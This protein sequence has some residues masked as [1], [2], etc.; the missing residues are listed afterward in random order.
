MAKTIAE[1]ESKVNRLAKAFASAN[2]MDLQTLM[3]YLD[4][5]APRL[6]KL[7]DEK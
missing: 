1:L 7:T 4:G 2:Q 5:K 3:A 6:E